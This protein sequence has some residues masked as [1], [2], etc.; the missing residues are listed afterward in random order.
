M[1]DTY[2]LLKW[3]HVLLAIL[4]VGF[5]ASYGV[6]LSRAAR[7]PEHMAFALQTVRALDRRFANPGYV[8]LLVTGLGMVHLGGWSLATPWIVVSLT[9]YTAIALLG[10]AAYAPLVRRQ[11]AVLAAAGA[12][13]P[14]FVSLQ[15]RNSAFGALLLV[16]VVAI[17]YL[18]VVKPPLW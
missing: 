3:A 13:S 15:K 6:I 8:L 9:L 11:A 5:N 4:A 7:A 14:E 10:I 1:A 2:L 16:L 12:T 17:E 18:M